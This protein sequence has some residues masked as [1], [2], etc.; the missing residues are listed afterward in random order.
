MGSR[1]YHRTRGVERTGVS[2]KVRSE[3]SKTVPR[4]GC[5]TNMPLNIPG[6]LAPFQLLWNPRIVL[7]HVI[8]TGQNDVFASLHLTDGV[9]FAAA[10]TF[11]S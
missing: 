11:A 2:G 6:L 1:L 5:V 4:G 9:S 8:V 3:A 7:P 10:K